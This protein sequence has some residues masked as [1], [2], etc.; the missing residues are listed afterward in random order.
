MSAGGAL[1]RVSVL[2]LGGT[3]ASAVS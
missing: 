1:P 3:I 2:A